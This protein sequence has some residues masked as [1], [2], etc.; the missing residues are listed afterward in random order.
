MSHYA[1]SDSDA[2]N[3]QDKETWLTYKILRGHLEDVYDLSWAPNSQQ[4]ISASVDN[5]AMVWDGKQ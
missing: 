2:S 5:T 3:D 4:L 1:F